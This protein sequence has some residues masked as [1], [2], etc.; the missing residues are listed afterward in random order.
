MLRK[1]AAVSPVQATVD[2]GPTNGAD[3]HQALRRAGLFDGVDFADA[4][5]LAQQFAMVGVDRGQIVFREGDPGGCLYIVIS[6]TVKLPRRGRDARP[7][8]IALRGPSEQLDELSLFD[9]GPHTVTA[10]VVTDGKLA[11]LPARALWTWVQERPQMTTQLLG[12]VAR[13]LRCT[14][15]RLSDLIFVDVPGRVAKVIMS[16]GRSFGSIEGDRVIVDHGL[17][18]D[19]LAQLVGASRETVNKAL[20]NFE[21]RGWLRIGPKSIVILEPDR[22]VRRTY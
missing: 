16:L 18:Q 6:G 5:V 8:V 3:V 20:R 12:I 13:R 10:T 21:S 17:T 22:L 1:A 7:S 11:C 15:T 19:E 4:E 14:T 9:P 2:G